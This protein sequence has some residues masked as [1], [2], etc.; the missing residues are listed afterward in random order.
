MRTLKYVETE[1]K[2]PRIK[3]DIFSLFQKEEKEGGRETSASDRNLN[4]ERRDEKQF[5]RAKIRGGKSTRRR[6]SDRFE[7][8]FPVWSIEISR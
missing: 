6:N 2:N 4:Y 3:E 1:A 5:P 7:F 8:P